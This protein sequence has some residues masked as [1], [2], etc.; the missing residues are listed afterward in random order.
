MNIPNLE[1]FYNRFCNYNT[2][3]YKY[4]LNL[5]EDTNDKKQMIEI[6]NKFNI[7]FNHSINFGKLKVILLERKNDK[8]K[9]YVSGWL[10]AQYIG[11]ILWINILNERNLLKD[12][13][14]TLLNVKF[15]NSF[16]RKYNNIKNY[17]GMCYN[18]MFVEKAFIP[19]YVTC[20]K[21]LCGSSFRNK[22]LETVINDIRR[23]GLEK[24]KVNKLLF[25]GSANNKLR[26][27]IFDFYREKDKYID[28][29]EANSKN[30]HY[31]INFIDYS[32]N[33]YIL[34]MNGINGHSGRRFF[35][36]HMNRVLFLP[37]DDPNK[38]FFETWDNPPKPFVHF[39]PYSLKKLPNFEKIVK[40]L[41]DNPKIYKKIQE[42]CYKYSKNNL[43]IERIEKYM[44]TLLNEVN[45]N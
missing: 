20:P 39:I 19:Y 44:I 24:P 26:R 28:F 10:Y 25:R 41:E 16:G 42:N 27:F 14:T 45:F 31:Y 37:T 40:H 38:L 15:R 2:N 23:K 11:H 29:K 33:K 32:D 34:D 7:Y 1:N 35:M 3:L 36:F 30:R 43:N 12:F 9:F 6:L 18:K 8:I 17:L 13:N 4:K 5:L 22:N 21:S